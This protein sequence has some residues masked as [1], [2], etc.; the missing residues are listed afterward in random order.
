MGLLDVF[1]NIRD[2]FEIGRKT[3]SDEPSNK[4]KKRNYNFGDGEKMPTSRAAYKEN[5]NSNNQKTN[6][7][8]KN[9]D[10]LEL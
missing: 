5:K 2:L 1:S 9:E 8:S 6:V 3:T 7:K 4:P 10:E